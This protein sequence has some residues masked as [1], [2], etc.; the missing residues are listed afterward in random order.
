MKR[1]VKKLIL[2]GGFVLASIAL[3]SGYEAME[4]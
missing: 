4:K 3:K 1:A 2:T